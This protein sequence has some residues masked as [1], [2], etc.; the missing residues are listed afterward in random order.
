MYI[1]IDE[2]EIAVIREAF[3]I[4]A[5]GIKHMYQNM[6]PGMTE[7]KL[8]KI[9]Q[10]YFK[11]EGSDSVSFWQVASGNLA[12]SPHAGTTDKVPAADEM[13][14][15]DIGALID[16]YTADST[17]SFTISGKFTK[18][19]K[20]IYDIVYKS[21]KTRVKGMVMTFEPAIYFPEDG[22]NARPRRLTRLVSEEEFMIYA[23]QMSLIQK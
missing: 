4:T 9:M 22:L 20:T 11:R 7:L 13:L 16:K 2:K 3:R 23:R 5:E 6:K 18:E 10:D 12:T 8:L 17:V 1:L 15:V 14:V 21:L 19:Q